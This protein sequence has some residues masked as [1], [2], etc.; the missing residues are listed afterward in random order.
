MIMSSRLHTIADLVPEGARVADIGTDHARL[1]PLL[2]TR[3]RAPIAI[4]I[5]RALPLAFARR[6][7]AR[8]AP[9]VRAQ[10]ELRAT[11][12]HG[13][14]LASLPLLRGTSA[15]NLERRPR[16]DPRAS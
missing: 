5:D 11:E 16:C 10:I 6:T 2:V 1:L 12:I 8:A 15:E 14:G 7:I 9:N 4:G 13:D 3:R